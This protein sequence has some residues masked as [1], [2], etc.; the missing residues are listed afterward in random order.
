MSTPLLTQLGI[1]YPIFLAPMAGITT[2]ELAVS[3]THRDVYTRQQLL[4]RAL[5]N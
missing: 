5:Q 3:C 2:P 4:L 1:R